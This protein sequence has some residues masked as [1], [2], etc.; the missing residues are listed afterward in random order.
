MNL[1]PFPKIFSLGTNYIRDIFKDPVEVTEKVDGSQFVFGKIGGELQIRSKGAAIYLASPPSMFKAGVDYVATLDLPEGVVYYCEFLAKPKHN[2]LTYGRIP[3]NHLCLFGV[4]DANGFHGRERVL[5]E[6][7][8]LDIDPVPLLLSGTVERPEELHG[9]MQ[10]DSYLGGAKV[11][12][13]VVKNYARPFLLGGQPIA[14]MAGKF[15]S[16]AFKEVHRGNWKKENTG[17]GK[18]DLFVEGYRTEARWEKAAQHLRDAGKLTNTPKDI[19]ILIAEV[20]RDISEEEIDEIKNF[21]WRE[22]GSELLRRAGAG[23]PEW[24][25]Q[26]LLQESFA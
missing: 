9:F 8:A 7:T 20:K 13:V 21:L 2:V 14:V 5:E 15:V 26:R 23:L 11:E 22:F 10:Q 16:E 25:K 4:M 19:G 24:W 3:K 18:W 6:A 1:S 17:R 12:G